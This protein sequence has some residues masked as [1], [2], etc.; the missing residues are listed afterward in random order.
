MILYVENQYSLR[1]IIPQ[2]FFYIEIVIIQ[3][4]K[5]KQVTNLTK[6]EAM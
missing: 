6:V 2:V 3:Y 1:F 4:G 5:T